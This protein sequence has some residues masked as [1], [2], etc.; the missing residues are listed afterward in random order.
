MSDQSFVFFDL[1]TLP[2]QDPDLLEQFRAEVKAPAQYKKQDSIDAWLSENRDAIAQEQMEKT[3]FDPAY[4]HICSIAWA[5][6]NGDI[7]TQCIFDLKD[8]ADLIA[9]FFASLDPYHSETLVGHYITGFDIP[10][11]LKRAVILGV[12]IPYAIPRDVKPWD[13]KV[14]D[15]M[16][17]WA[18]AKGSI[19]Q[20]KLARILGIDGKGDFDGSMVADAWARGE[21]QRIAEYNADDVRTVREIHRKFMKAGW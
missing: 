1:E 16:H 12:K 3:S 4:G 21:Y 13:K 18:G 6:N 9:S 14:H 11:I 2:S 17:M 8:E 20:D 10:F 15:T 19:S 5:K 7:V